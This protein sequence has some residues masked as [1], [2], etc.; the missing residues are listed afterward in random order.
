MF[1]YRVLGTSGQN[2][3]NIYQYSG[4]KDGL[5]ILETTLKCGHLS[6]T[7]PDTLSMYKV[8]SV[9]NIMISF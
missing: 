1:I 4:L 6:P 3:S 2:V 7:S 5:E 9:N 8:C